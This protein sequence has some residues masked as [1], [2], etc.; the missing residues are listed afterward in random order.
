MIAVLTTIAVTLGMTGCNFIGTASYED[1]ERAVI[2]N[3]LKSYSSVA[4][5]MEKLAGGN[6]K[7]SETLTLTIT[8]EQY[9]IDLFDVDKLNPTIFE[10]GTVLDGDKVYSGVVYKNGDKEILSADLWTDTSG[11][12]LIAH[13]PRLFEKYLSIDIEAFNEQLGDMGGVSSFDFE[14]LTMPSDKAFKAVLDVAM[15]E[16]FEM[17]ADVETEEDVELNIDGTAVVTNK[18]VVELTEEM[19]YKV[20]IAT[21]KEIQNNDEIKNFINEFVEMFDEDYDFDFDEAISEVIEELEDKLADADDD[22]IATMTVFINGS[23][24]V[25]RIVEFEDTEITLTTF[26]DVKNLDIATEI[27]GQ[28]I[29]ANLTFGDNNLEG[30]LSLGSV[31]VA[32]VAIEWSD[33]YDGKPEPELNSVN[34][35]DLTDENAMM[36]LL[37]AVMSSYNEILQDYENHGHDLIGY[38]LEDAESLMSMFM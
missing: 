12:N 20:L 32:T 18:T 33:D 30:G 14:A 19:M 15:D 28:K 27:M 11:N 31:R 6:A 34:S 37:M 17:I 3:G 10:F 23:K 2:E 35:L 38:F 8:P 36:E 26:D 5:L 21:F 16:Y 22:V 1:A 4:E 29:E 7:E 24:I 13:L 25:R 9:L